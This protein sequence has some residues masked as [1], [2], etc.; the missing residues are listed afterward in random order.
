MARP[1]DDADKL[2]KNRQERRELLEGLSP[3]TDDLNEVSEVT[4]PEFHV[5]VPPHPAPPP[6]RASLASSETLLGVLDRTPPKHRLWVV[7]A[8]VLAVLAAVLAGKVAFGAH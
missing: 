1:K 5:H 3:Y 7:L 2:L 4:V 6:P 8:V